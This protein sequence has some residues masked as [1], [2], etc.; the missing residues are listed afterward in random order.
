M[1]SH[2]ATLR[3]WPPSAPVRATDCDTPRIDSGAT[4]RPPGRSCSSMAATMAGCEAEL[5]GTPSR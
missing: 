2:T 1:A 4:S 5:V 3:S